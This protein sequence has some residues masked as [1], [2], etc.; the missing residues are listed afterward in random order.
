MTYPYVQCRWRTPTDG[1]RIDLVVVHTAETPEGVD[2]AMAV[3]RYFATTDTKASAHYCV[4]G[5]GHIVQSCRERDVAY[6][7]PGANSNG[8]HVELAGRAAQS[9]ADWHDPY[10]TK[11]LATAAPLVADVCKRYGIPVRYVSSAALKAG[12]AGARGI[13]MHRDVSDAF[14]K[15]THTDPGPN[16]PMVEFVNAVLGGTPQPPRRNAVVHQYLQSLVA[17]NGGT[18]HLQADGGI[19]TDTD[20]LDGPMAPFY[21]SVPGAGGAGDARVR[22]ILPHGQGYKVVVQHPDESVSYFHFPAT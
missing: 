4:D 5:G 13:T 20:G 19:I 6:A 21:G 1:R 17:P 14:R 10:S 22:G 9:A 3:A 2:T 12:G 7:A 15:S 11:L 18:W 8:V 16:F